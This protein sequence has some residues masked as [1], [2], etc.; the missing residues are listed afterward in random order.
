MEDDSQPLDLTQWDYNDLDFLY[1][2]AVRH[3]PRALRLFP[4]DE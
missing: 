4:V 2:S 1:A 3:Y